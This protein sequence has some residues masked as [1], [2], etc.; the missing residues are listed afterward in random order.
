MANMAMALRGQ[1]MCA[2]ACKVRNAQD[3]WPDRR[4][5]CEADQAEQDAIGVRPAGARA[6]EGVDNRRGRDDV[7]REV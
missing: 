4:L 3:G 1:Y 7:C 5:Q 6:D 2:T